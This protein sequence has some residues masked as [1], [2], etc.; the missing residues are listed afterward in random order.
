MSSAKVLFAIYRPGLEIEAIPFLDRSPSTTVTRGWSDATTASIASGTNASSTPS[1][2]SA[3]VPEPYVALDATFSISSRRR[4]RMAA[5]PSRGRRMRRAITATSRVG[6]LGRI[7]SMA[8][9][10]AWS[11]RAPLGGL[12][13]FRRKN[14]PGSCLAALD[15]NSRDIA[16]GVSSVG[17]EQPPNFNRN[18]E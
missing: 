13:T 15:E 6:R 8:G 17:F 18:R 1:A 7:G 16:K 11:N 2:A 10:P 12:P 9:G 4:P 14:W 5:N 3:G